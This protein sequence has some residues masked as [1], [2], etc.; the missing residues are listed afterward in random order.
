[1]IEEGSPHLFLNETYIAINSTAIKKTIQS[2]SLKLTDKY[3]IC[4]HN[5]HNT[6][7]FQLNQV[8]FDGNR[9]FINEI[10]GSGKSATIIETKNKESLK[11]AYRAFVQ[12]VTRGNEL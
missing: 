4:F 1:V 3:L 2:D 10:E 12:K 6:D 7:T 11:A 8:L 9:F 5:E